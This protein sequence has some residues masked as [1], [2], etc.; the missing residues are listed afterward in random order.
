MYSLMS[1]IMSGSLTGKRTSTLA[2]RLRGIM[3][4]DPMY[5]SGLSPFWK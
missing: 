5:I 4:E 3:S 2:S 1:I